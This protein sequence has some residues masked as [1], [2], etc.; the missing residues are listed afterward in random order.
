M[1]ESSEAEWVR[2]LLDV[3]RALTAELDTAVVL[4]RLLEGAREITGARYAAIGVLDDGQ[5]ELEQFLTSGIDAAVRSSMGDLPRGRGVLGE[6]IEHPHPLRLR[7][8]GQHPSSYGFP[9][10]HPPMHSFLGVPVKI[11]GRV[12]GNL[13]LTEKAHGEFTEADE[14]AA[15]ILAQW[16]AIAI[17]NARLYEASERA[18]RELEKALLGLEA[19]R[20]VSAAIGK[21]ITLEHVL[22]IIV[23]RGRA[24]VS[25]QSLVIMLRDGTELVVHTSAGHVKDLR[26]ARLPISESTSGEVL[27]SHRPE[28]ISDV[29]SRL[30]IDP[31]EFGVT[32]PQTG[33]LVPMVYRGRAVGILAA[34]DRGAERN[35]FTD[36]DE[37]M[38]RT[39]AAS[40]ATAVA[41][42]QSVQADRLHTSLVAGEVERS[43]WA[44]ELHDETLQGLGGLR[45]LLS[46]AVRRGEPEHAKKAM[47]E[48]VAH[49]ER[50][51]ENLR[52]IISELRPAALDEL[53]LRTAIEALLD[54]HRDQNGLQIEQAL[55]LPGPAATSERL[56]SEIESTVYRLVQ[57]ALSNIVKHSEADKVRVAI[58]EAN[59][60]LLVEVKDDGVGFDTND[61]SHGFGLLGMQE[62]V[63][64]AG[65][66]LSV[67]SGEHGT[68]VFA[69]VPARR[70]ESQAH[71]DSERAAAGQ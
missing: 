29:T 52:A 54:R 27:E 20:D 59:G 15:V 9:A 40:A 41:L 45:L 10:G 49:I 39:F 61:S 66:T 12:W 8:I 36:D 68:L 47:E 21:E 58:G 2:R 13:Y 56:D 46:S 4:E 70:G 14:E 69:W 32:D 37:E 17:E 33:L 35:S 43:R 38:L 57:E 60:E 7:D 55:T 67:S 18:R 44:R 22:E 63:G 28:R 31:R 30:R 48:A 64:L 50:E 65:G 1:A 5:T 51:I 6:L 26:G 71:S 23:K 11:S 53:G 3:G 34:F 16:A 42:A 24:L 19:I 25:A 62:R